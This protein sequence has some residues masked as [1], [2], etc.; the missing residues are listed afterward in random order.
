MLIEFRFKNFRSFR[1]ETVLSMEASGIQN[2]NHSLIKYANYKI[3]PAAAIFGKN[4]W[5]KSNV[6][7]AFWLAVQFIQNVQLTQHENAPVPVVPFALNDYSAGKPTEFE[8]LYTIDNVKYYYSFAVTREKIVNECLYHSPKW[9]KA[10]VFSREGQKFK[11]SEEK[12]KT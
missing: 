11:F 5:G 4:G 12:N 1:N 7:R 3:L 2:F 9:Q 6:I 10:L 8:F